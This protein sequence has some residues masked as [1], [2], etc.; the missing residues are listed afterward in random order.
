MSLKDVGKKRGRLNA[1]ESYVALR[2]YIESRPNPATQDDLNML[3]E[4]RQEALSAG[5]AGR[6]KSNGSPP[7]NPKGPG[8]RPT[9][10]KMVF[11]RTTNGNGV[12]MAASLN[13][14]KSDV[15]ALAGSGFGYELKC[16]RPSCSPCSFSEP[17]QK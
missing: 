7:R 2:N 1:V 3:R 14:G 5:D 6:V 11:P 10:H 8:S 15:A 16:A 17:N 12:Q 4:A 13:G 9:D